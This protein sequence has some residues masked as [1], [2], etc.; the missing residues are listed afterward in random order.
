MSKGEGGVGLESPVGPCWVK[1]PVEKLR[2]RIPNSRQF[3]NSLVRPNEWL[4]HIQA[5]PKIE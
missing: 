5:I 2:L 1:A 4:L 3:F